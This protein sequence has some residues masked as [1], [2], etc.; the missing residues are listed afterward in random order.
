MMKLEYES[1][2]AAANHI[3]GKVE[4][5]ICQIKDFE[6]NFE[7]PTFFCPAIGNLC[8]RTINHYQ[9]LSFVSFT[10]DLENFDL[11]KPKRLRLRL[12]H[13]HSQVGSLETVSSQIRFL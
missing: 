8:N 12:N 10:G 9:Q 6:K 5:K 2:L 4:W 1:Y 3:Y 11:I 13:D 7:I